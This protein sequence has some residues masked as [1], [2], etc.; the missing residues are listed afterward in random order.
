MCMSCNF[1]T[2][3]FPRNIYLS[4][5]TAAKQRKSCSFPDNFLDAFTE[6]KANHKA[7]FE[8]R[9]KC[10]FFVMANLI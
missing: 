7:A 9:K 10:A 2:K 8:S 4:M 5:L 6:G 3:A 1:V